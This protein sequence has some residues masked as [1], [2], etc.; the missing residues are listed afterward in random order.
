MTEW[1]AVTDRLPE[2]GVP[3]LVTLLTPQP[4]VVLAQ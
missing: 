1:I 2:A 3:V 4:C